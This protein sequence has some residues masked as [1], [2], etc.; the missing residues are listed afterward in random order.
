MEIWKIKEHT[1]ATRREEV[2]CLVHADDKME[3]I[4]YLRLSGFNNNNIEGIYILYQDEKTY[5]ASPIESIHVA[6][7]KLGDK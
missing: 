6:D 2:Y 5:I 3:I 1:H 4:S 7:F